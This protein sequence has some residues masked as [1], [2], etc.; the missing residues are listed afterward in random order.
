MPK[1]YLI[2][3]KDVSVPLPPP[4]RGFLPADGDFVE[5]D[6]YWQR[7]INDGDASIG[8]PPKVK[9]DPAP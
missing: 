5:M 7:I 8:K 2:P 3:A 9:A 4:S 1:I 6:V